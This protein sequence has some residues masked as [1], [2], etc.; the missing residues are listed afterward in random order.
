MMAYLLPGQALNHFCPSLRYQ[1]KT[2]FSFTQ[3]KPDQ[4]LQQMVFMLD[5][6]A[7]AENVV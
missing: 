1:L 2:V 5:F 7:T 6:F 3:Q 4:N